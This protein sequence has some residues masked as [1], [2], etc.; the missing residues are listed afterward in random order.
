MAR[1]GS[2]LSHFELQ[3]MSWKGRRE[4]FWSCGRLRSRAG[5]HSTGEDT[6]VVLDSPVAV[7]GPD[8]GSGLL[9]DGLRVCDS[10]GLAG[11]V[12]QP[13]QVGNRE[14]ERPSSDLRVEEESRRAEVTRGLPREAL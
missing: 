7:E 3:N 4:G 13:D 6:Q 12:A 9:R 2:T 10:A 5:R 14:L 8:A 1:V 11:L